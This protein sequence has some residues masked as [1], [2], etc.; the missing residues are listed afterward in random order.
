MNALTDYL[1]FLVRAAK[2]LECLAIGVLGFCP[3]PYRRK[4]L[5]IACGS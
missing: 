3:K 2:S 4:H 1:Q 5:L